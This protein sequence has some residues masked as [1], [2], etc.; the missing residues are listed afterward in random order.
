MF[1]VLLKRVFYVHQKTWGAPKARAD[2]Q[3]THF[4]GRFYAYAMDLSIAWIVDEQRLYIKNIWGQSFI[5][6]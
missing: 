4:L 6:R 5:C 2:F 1:Y 3:P